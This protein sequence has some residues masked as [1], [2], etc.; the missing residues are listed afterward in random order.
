M[1]I[2]NIGGIL[3]W[4]FIRVLCIVIDEFGRGRGIWLGLIFDGFVIEVLFWFIVG[5]VV[6]VW[7]GNGGG[8]LYFSDGCIE[9]GIG[10]G[11]VWNFLK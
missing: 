3:V 7:V 11:G 8:M 4:L 5:I 10:G 1:S 6:M 9:F 2:K